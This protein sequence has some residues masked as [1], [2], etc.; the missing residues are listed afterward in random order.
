MEKFNKST[1]FQ[2]DKKWCNKPECHDGVVEGD[3]REHV[4]SCLQNTEGAEAVLEVDKLQSHIL[5]YESS[6]LSFPE[7]QRWRSLH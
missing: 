7:S 1:V 6:I 4:S 5:S 2:S 3:G